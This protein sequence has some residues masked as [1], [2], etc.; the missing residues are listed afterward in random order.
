MFHV[1]Q[2]KRGFCSVSR[3]TI[4]ASKL[5]GATTAILKGVFK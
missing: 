1:K 4:F 5:K 2:I 3:E